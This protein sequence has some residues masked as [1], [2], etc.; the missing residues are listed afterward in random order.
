VATIQPNAPLFRSR[1]PGYAHQWIWEALDQTDS[2]GDW[3]DLE[4][5]SNRTFHAI[6]GFGGGTLTIE[7]SND[8]VGTLPLNATMTNPTN[9]GKLALSFTAE[10]VKTAL[11]LCKWVRPVLTGG[12]GSDVDVILVA[13]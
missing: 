3:V 8:K 12:A 11:E 10:G 9:G 4:G 5:L 6:G 13:W 7:G 1:S 2:D